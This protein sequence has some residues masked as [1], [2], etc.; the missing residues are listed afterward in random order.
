MLLADDLLDGLDEVVPQVPPIGDLL[1]I[2]RADPDGFGVGAGA[3]ATHDLHPGVGT[4][5]GG[6][7]VAGPVSQQIQRPMGGHV[8]DDGAVDMAAA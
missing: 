5:P 1:C 3:V 8:D 6:E 7:G 4:Q 2:R